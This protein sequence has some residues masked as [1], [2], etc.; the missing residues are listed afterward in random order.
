[1]KNGEGSLVKLRQCQ[2]NIV[3]HYKN[4]HQSCSVKSICRRDLIYEPSKNVLSDSDAEIILKT[5]IQ[6]LQIYK[7]PYDYVSC[8]DTHYVESFN[9]ALLI[10]LEKE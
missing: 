6:K 7:T 2:D 9:D 4:N 10:Y 8:I 5:E 3:G 1:M